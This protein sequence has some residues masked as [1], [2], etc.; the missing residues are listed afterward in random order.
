M[1]DGAL[2]ISRGVATGDFKTAYRVRSNID[3][4]GAPLAPMNGSHVVEVSG[5]YVGPC[6]SG[7]RPGDVKLGSGLKVNLDRLPRLAGAIAGG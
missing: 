5:R 6:P 2:V 1:E 7:M 4:S 3:V